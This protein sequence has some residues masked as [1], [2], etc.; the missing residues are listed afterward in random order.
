MHYAGMLG[1]SR[2]CQR[3]QPPSFSVEFDLLDEALGPQA[4][5][6][7]SGPSASI[8]NRYFSSVGGFSTRTAGTRS[9]RYS[10]TRGLTRRKSLSQALPDELKQEALARIQSIAGPRKDRRGNLF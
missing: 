2:G 4:A 8:P 9:S 3:L 10:L 1:G 7:I 6:E 5:V